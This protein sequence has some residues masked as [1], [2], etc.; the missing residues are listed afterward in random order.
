MEF[1]AI[2]SQVEG[3][4]LP[5]TN[6]SDQKISYKIESPTLGNTELN[7]EDAYF[8]FDSLC[9]DDKFISAFSAIRDYTY[10]VAKM[11]VSDA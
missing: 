4:V 7:W 11:N 10:N 8:N 1:N 2:F 6:Y 3:R 5:Q 9:K